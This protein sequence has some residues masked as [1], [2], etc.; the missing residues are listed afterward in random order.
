MPMLNYGALEHGKYYIKVVQ[1]FSLSQAL[2]PKGHSHTRL[3]ARDHTFQALSLVEKVE[4]VQVSLTLC[5]RNQR[6]MRM[7]DG[8]KVYMDSYMASNG[9]FSWSLGLFSKITSWGRPNTKPGNYGILNA[10]DLFYFIMG[11]SPHE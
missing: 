3:R 5:L 7:Q 9:L 11:E 4:P 2:D 8:C 1:G 6:S 10:H